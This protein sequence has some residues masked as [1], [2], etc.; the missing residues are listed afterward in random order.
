MRFTPR[1]PEEIQ[2]MTLIAPGTYD[3]TVV[4]SK[5]MLSKSGNE[6]IKLQLKVWDMNGNE[7]SVFDY[8]LEA[9]A[10]KLRHFCEATGLLNKYEEG[11]FNA[12]DCLG[13][14]GKVEIIIQEGNFKPDGSKYA[15]KNAVKD[16]CKPI[17]G[18]K[19]DAPKSDDFDNSDEIPF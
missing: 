7:R 13:K 16:Y 9:M 3:F 12:E 19:V 14:S 1:T 11:G 15:D 17:D 2:S 5:E 18:A 6:M 4:E 10:F 8:L